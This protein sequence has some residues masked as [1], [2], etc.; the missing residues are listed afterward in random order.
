MRNRDIDI[1][2][3]SSTALTADSLSQADYI[4]A[5]TRS[6]LDAIVSIMKGHETPATLLVEGED[7]FD[8]IGGSEDDYERCARV[9]EVGVRARLEEIEL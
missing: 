1:S 7:V 9:I 3:H 8:P 6:H 2:G 5:M 4:F